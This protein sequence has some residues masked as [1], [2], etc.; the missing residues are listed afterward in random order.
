MCCGKTAAPRRPP[1]EAVITGGRD[2]RALIGDLTLLTLRRR[3]LVMRIPGMPEADQ[4]RLAG[5]IGRHYAV[6]GCDQGRISGIFTL[7]A[8]TVL[9]IADFIPLS[10]LG[11]P[12]VVGY[13]FLCSF[14]TMFAG[15]LYGLWRARAGLARLADQ[16]SSTPNPT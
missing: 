12:R 13:Y 8:Y 6:C 15:K 9:V 11:W 14:I 1:P 16:L 10:E 5:I 4:T 2:V 3:K 7:L